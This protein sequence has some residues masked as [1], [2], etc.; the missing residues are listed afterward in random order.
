MEDIE[1]R[2]A[3]EKDIDA[4]NQ[5]YNRIYQRKRTKEQFNWEFNSAPAGKAIYVVAVDKD[6]IVGTQ[7]AIPYYILDKEGKTRLTAKSEDTLVDPKYRGKQ[8]FENMY[9]Q[10]LMECRK[11]GI[12][13]I[14]GFTYAEKP[15]KN[16]G[17]D[18]PY[19]SAMGLIVLKT[20]PAYKYYSNLSTKNS[21][22][23]KLKIF[24]L[25]VKSGMDHFFSN[26]SLKN[27]LPLTEEK[28]ALNTAQFNYLSGSNC[29]GLKLD[30]AF[31]NY[32]LYT[33]PYSKNYFQCTYKEGEE[34]KASIIFTVNRGIG[35]IL[36]I[37]MKDE[38][39]GKD[40]LRTVLKKSK[41]AE[42]FTVRFW[43]FK[44]NALNSKE[45]DLLKNLNFT[46]V[47]KGISFVGMTLTK[48]SVSWKD[49]HL[50]RL[51][52]QGTD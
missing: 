10:L 24:G 8:I 3:G 17:F 12:G 38:V 4:I 2:L 44:H 33:N 40:F 48:D 30:E 18:I 11:A 39:I 32:R 47:D 15:F 22:I 49:F 7:C 35:Y 13:F 28:I 6:K 37:F 1:L 41:L 31:L 14:W 9:F 23:R 26:R 29:Y 20:F 34:V 51:A 5:F 42:C 50:S 25:C 19:H 36:H 27:E 16:I 21:F 43:G 45:L 52:S 46:F